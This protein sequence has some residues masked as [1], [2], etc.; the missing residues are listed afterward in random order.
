M[1]V[2]GSRARQQASSSTWHGDQSQRGPEGQGMPAGNNYQRDSLR[3]SHLCLRGASFMGGLGG[4]SK[5]EKARQIRSAFFSFPKNYPREVLG[6][7]CANDPE[8]RARPRGRTR[9]GQRGCCSF[10]F[11]A[12]CHPSSSCS[13]L[14]ECAGRWRE[15]LVAER[16]PRAFLGMLEWGPGALEGC[17]HWAARH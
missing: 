14:A 3:Y 5:P 2:I 10:A 13:D 4:N 1:S 16:W 17:L 6:V 11:R 9:N 15:A 12:S 7:R 8:F